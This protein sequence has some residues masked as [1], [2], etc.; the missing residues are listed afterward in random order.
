MALKEALVMVAGE[1]GAFLTQVYSSLTTLVPLRYQVAVN[2]VLYSLLMAFYGFF[3][4]K[5]HRTLAKRDIIALDFTKYRWS[6]HPFLDKLSTAVYFVL[7]HIIIMPFLVTFWFGMLAVFLLLLSKS[8][9]AETV[10]MIAATVIASTRILS[11]YSNDLSKD[12]AKLFPLTLLVVFLIDSNFFVVSQ[13]IGRIEE[14][15]ALMNNILI[16]LVTIVILELI[17]KS[18]FAFIKITSI[19]N[20]ETMEDTT[21]VKEIVE[22][23]KEEQK[24]K[25]IVVVKKEDVFDYKPSATV[26]KNNKYLLPLKKVEK[27]EEKP[28]KEKA[29]SKLKK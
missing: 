16:Y 18:I 23:R 17:L 6:N 3:V 8:Q 29:K 21:T 15:P 10:V 22:N 24:D 13:F 19:S 25:P 4:W 9:S 5:F 7:E 20:D 26:N 12:I 28:E 2:L 27:A 11:Y 1:I 14:L